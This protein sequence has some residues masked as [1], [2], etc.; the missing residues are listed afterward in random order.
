MDL[1]LE[2]VQLECEEAMDKAV[3]FLTHELRSIRTGRA[4]TGLI[5]HVKVDAYGSL[6]DL[7]NMAGLS[8]PEA[9]QILVKPFDPSTV[10]SIVKAIEAADLGLN[11]QSDGKQVRVP[12]PA[13]SGERRKHLAGQVKSMGEQAKVTLRN[14]RRDANKHLDQISKDKSASVSEDTVKDAKDDIQNKIKAH[15]AT[16]ESLV[17]NRSAEIMQV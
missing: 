4:T 5:E 7:K 17:K 12:V 10:N 16:I 11:P 6:Q 8:T 1:D 3:E 9:T 15:E 14:A 13:L 2:T